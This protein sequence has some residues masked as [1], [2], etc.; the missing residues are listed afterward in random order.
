MELLYEYLT[1]SHFRQRIEAIVEAF[2]SMQD[3]LAKERRLITKQWAKRE[4]EIDTV[5]RSTV[6][7][8]GDFQGIA[9]KTL[10]ELDGLRLPQLEGS[11]SNRFEA[12]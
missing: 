1:G 7:M 8:W 2:T 4:R 9:G 10:P 11:A 12:D 5:M 6:G 3:D